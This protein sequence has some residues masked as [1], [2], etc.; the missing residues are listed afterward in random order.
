M[1]L[2][3]SGK[4]Y[5]QHARSQVREV[6][7]SQNTGGQVREELLTVRLLVVRLGKSY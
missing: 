2:V 7:D 1:L 4:S 6:T 5:C 3:S